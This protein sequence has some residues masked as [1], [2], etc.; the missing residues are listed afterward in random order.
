M[1]IKTLLI[2][3][4]H[5]LVSI[6]HLFDVHLKMGIYADVVTPPSRRLHF[7][8]HI[9]SRVR[10]SSTHLIYLIGVGAL[11]FLVMRLGMHRVVSTV[12]SQ[13]SFC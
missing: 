12:V 6:V 4:S 3:P 11:V 8:E 10:P 5:W 2:L 9:L 7:N 13:R 1:F